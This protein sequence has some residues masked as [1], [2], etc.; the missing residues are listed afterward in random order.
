MELLHNGS[1]LHSGSCNAIFHE[2]TITE[3]LQGEYQCRVYFPHNENIM[4]LESEIRNLI[5]RGKYA[6]LHVL[7][8]ISQGF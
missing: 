3:D 2:V 1:R 5:V 4:T 7:Q 6:K 8:Y